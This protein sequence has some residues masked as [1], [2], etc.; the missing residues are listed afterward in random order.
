MTKRSMEILS[1]IALREYSDVS[2]KDRLEIL[3]SLVMNYILMLSRDLKISNS[4]SGHL[5]GN[6]LNFEVKG[7]LQKL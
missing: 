2:F 7:D 4:F 5:S 1:E 6:N 3:D